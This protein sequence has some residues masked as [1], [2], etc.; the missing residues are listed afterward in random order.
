MKMETYIGD[1]LYYHDCVIVPG[2]GGFVANYR[3]AQIHPVS[4]NMHP[5]S[6]SIGFNVQLQ[7]NDGLLANYLA[8][9]L[10]IS[11]SEAQ[12][13]IEQFVKKIHNNL[14]HKKEA[15]LKKIGVLRMDFEGNISFEPDLQTNYLLDSFGLET[16]Q[17]PAIIRK[18]SVLD[19]SK[20]LAK[21]VSETGEQVASNWKVAAVIVPLIGLSTYISFQQESVQE[22]Y[23]NY[24]YLNPF[25]KKPAAMYIP[26]VSENTKE[27]H[28]E[29]L[30]EE[31]ST[32][33]TSP[34]KD[35]E[36][37]KPIA[38]PETKTIE[39][40][41]PATSSKNQYHLVAGC[42]AS[43]ENADN[44]TK[45]LQDQ[46]FNSSIIGQN[47]KGL[48]RVVFSSHANRKTAMLKME[49]LKKSGKSTWLLKQ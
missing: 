45:T 27:I 6:K 22:A 34:I 28:I 20:E 2:L 31:I 40:A 41:V 26:R 18:P 33:K 29:K 43:K 12:S 32:K 49:T 48:F 3:S 39:I 7:S 36:A 21:K 13:K 14:E 19:L 38:I 47:P 11:F 1:L 35:V 37:A 15:R 4:H 8:E 30:T 42:F 16:I 46:G 24:A 25:K 44:L 23:A 9:C 5:P 10:S 17:S